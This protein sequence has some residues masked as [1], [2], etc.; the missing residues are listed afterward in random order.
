MASNRGSRGSMRFTR[1]VSVIWMSASGTQEAGSLALSRQPEAS[2]AYPNAD[3]WYCLSLKTPESSLASY[4][5]FLGDHPHERFAK[6]HIEVEL[7]LHLRS[8]CALLLH[9][10]RKERCLIDRAGAL[11]GSLGVSHVRSPLHWARSSMPI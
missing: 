4:L 1:A 2:N 6:R 3:C 9:Q 5:Q 8:G 7:V 11:L 10:G